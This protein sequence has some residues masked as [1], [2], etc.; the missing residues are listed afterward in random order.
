MAERKDA[1]RIPFTEAQVEIRDTLI[2]DRRREA[3][4]AYLE[5]IR[6][7]TPVWTVFDNPGGSSAAPQFTAGR[8][9]P[10]VTR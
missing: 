5:K 7:R 10:S 8:P 3:T 2:T 4:D 9:T 1:G 6:Q